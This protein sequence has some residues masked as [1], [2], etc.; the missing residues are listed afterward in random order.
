MV[1]HP[2][3]VMLNGMGDLVWASDEYGMITDFKVQEYEGERYLTFWAGKN[4]ADHSYG[5]GKYYMVYMSHVT[6]VQADQVIAR[7]FL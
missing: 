2:G 5:L 1:W 6:T 4:G 3:P 7:C